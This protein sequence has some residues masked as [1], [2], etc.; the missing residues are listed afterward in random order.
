MKTVRALLVSFAL[1]SSLSA[2]PVEVIPPELRGASQPQVAVAPSGRVHIVFGK[3]NAIYYTSSADGKTFAP[4]VKVAEVNKLA[5]GMR[6]GPR[7][8]AT[9]Q[10]VLVTGNSSA[11]GNLHSWI[12]RDAGRAWKEGPPLN[13]ASGSAKEGLHSVAGD[14]HGLVAAV[15]L[16]GRGRGAEVRSRVSRDGGATWAADTSVYQSPEGHV[17]E[18]CDPSVAID[19]Q[20]RVAVMFRNSLG[21]SRDMYASV[22][23]DGGRTFGKAQ[24]L[25]KG[26]WPLNAC[27][28]DGGAI[29][30]GPGGQVL[31]AWRREKT[32]FATA[33]DASE[34]KLSDSASQPVVVTGKSGAYYFWE[35]G[36]SVMM[37]KGDS[38]PTRLGKGRFAAAASLANG[39]PVVVWESQA[40]GANTL[41]AEVID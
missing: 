8:T 6:R 29:T 33:G 21:G 37:Q 17:C 2:A 22:S 31:T 10:I 34:R 41:L 15:W 40:N 16:D 3:E 39:A 1:A 14:G 30:F 27:P 11:D 25:G 18:C 36:G 38:A 4:P 5:L 20:G 35:S 24:K 19:A 32:T 9:D 26:T 13:S 12:S 7:V 28:M 23:A